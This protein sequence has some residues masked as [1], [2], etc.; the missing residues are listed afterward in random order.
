MSRTKKAKR[1]RG[2][3]NAQERERGSTGGSGGGIGAGRE[4][5]RGS[6]SGGNSRS[7][8]RSTGPQ[9][10]KTKQSAS[11]QYMPRVF[12]SEENANGERRVAWEGFSDRKPD[13]TLELPISKG[14]NIDGRSW[15]VLERRWDLKIAASAATSA[16]AAVARQEYKH[17]LKKPRTQNSGR[18]G[19]RRSIIV[20][21][22]VGSC[23]FSV[24]DERAGSFSLG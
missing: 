20:A 7:G 2:K 24:S 18:S 11:K 22:A 10:W 8:G 16:A 17:E 13:T 15:E 23:E 3:G 5:G 12:L 1:G 14:G 4:G 6:G 21:E 9:S 19:A